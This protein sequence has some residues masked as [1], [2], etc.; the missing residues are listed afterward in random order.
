[1]SQINQNNIPDPSRTPRGELRAIL[2]LS[3]PTVVITAS[4]TVVGFTDMAMVSRLGTE[5][6]AALMPANLTLFCLIG[7]GMGIMSAVNT[8][9]SQSLGR[10]RPQDGARYMVQSQIVSL[11]FAL[12][13]LPLIAAVPTIVSWFGHD[14]GVRLLEQS[15]AQIGLLSVGPSVAAVGVSYYFV[16][17]HRPRVSMWASLLEV[18]V[19]L[20]GNYVFIFGKFGLPALGVAGCAWSTV[21]ASSVRLVLLLICFASPYYRREFRTG[22]AWHLDLKRLRAL[23]RVGWPIGASFGAELVSW[24]VFTVYLVGRFGTVH[25]AANN[26]V[27]QYLHVSFMPAIG[28]GMAVSALVGKAIGQRDIPLAVHRTWLGVALCVGWMGLCGLGFLVFR[29]PLMRLWTSDPEVI[30][31]GAQLMICCAI[32]QVFDGLGIACMSALRGAGDNLVPGIYNVL[33][34]WIVMVLGGWLVGELAPQWTSI[35]PWVMSSAF[36]ILFSITLWVRFLRGS[37]KKID[38]F[39]PETA[40]DSEPPID[41]LIHVAETG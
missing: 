38:L 13:A 6:A 36:I 4:R 40:E 41:P 10:D 18:A 1:M 2:V 31:L 28:I 29:F 37:W 39:A 27:F 25:L 16:G 23:L 17:I 30:Q 9:A 20:V 3:L 8:F 22:G 21:L 11:G 5:A 15:Y 24:S 12:V 7:L 14:E 34:C 35:G 26:F 33:F 32:F 19:N